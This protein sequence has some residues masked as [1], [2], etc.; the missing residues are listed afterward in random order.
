MQTVWESL[1]VGTSPALKTRRCLLSKHCRDGISCQKAGGGGGSAG[2]FSKR[3]VNLLASWGTSSWE[4]TVGV[5]SVQISY[6]ALKF[7][8]S[9]HI[10]V[11]YIKFSSSA[12][13][14]M[15]HLAMLS[16]S[17][18]GVPNSDLTRSRK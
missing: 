13:L 3:K 16:V 2:G 7:H 15:I 8:L 6:Q 9:Q 18:S 14:F 4:R 1:S 10:N 5:E 17:R 11:L 12:L